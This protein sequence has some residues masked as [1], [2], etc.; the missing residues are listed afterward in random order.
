MN[1]LLSH[2][3]ARATEA[4][5]RVSE[6]QVANDRAAVAEATRRLADALRQLEVELANEPPYNQGARGTDG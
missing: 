1:T 3:P 5:L 4:S 6:A 2:L